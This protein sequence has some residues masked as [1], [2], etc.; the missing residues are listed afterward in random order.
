MYVC[1]EINKVFSFELIFLHIVIKY[2]EIIRHNN[3]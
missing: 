2:I 3:I 1:L